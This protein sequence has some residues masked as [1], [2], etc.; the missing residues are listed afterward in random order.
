MMSIPAS[1]ALNK[2]SLLLCFL[3]LGVAFFLS[4]VQQSLINADATIAVSIV[5]LFHSQFAANLNIVVTG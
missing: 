3:G 5:M 1:H 2:A 4:Q